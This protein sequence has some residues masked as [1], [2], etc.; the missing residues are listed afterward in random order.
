MSGGVRAGSAAGHLA[1]LCTAHHH[2]RHGDRWTYTLHPDGT[3]HWT[4]PTGR[5]MT[6]RP[7]DLLPDPPRRR[8]A[9]LFEAKWAA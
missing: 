5:R 4:T 2:V 9:P 3:A 6:T 1:S 7:G 8:P